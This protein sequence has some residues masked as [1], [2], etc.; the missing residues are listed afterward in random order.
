MCLFTN[1]SNYNGCIMVLLMLTFVLLC[2]HSFLQSYKGDDLWYSHHGFSMGLNGCTLVAAMLAEALLT[3]EMHNVLEIAGAIAKWNARLI[4]INRCGTC[5]DEQTFR[6]FCNDWIDYRMLSILI[7]INLNEK[8]RNKGGHLHQR[9]FSW[10]LIPNVN[11][12]MAIDPFSQIQSQLRVR[13]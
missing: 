11:D 2:G 4:L 7:S 5:L 8:S 6:I 10:Q 9:Y 12:L 1:H 13:M 3:L